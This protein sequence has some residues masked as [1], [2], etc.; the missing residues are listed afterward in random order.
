MN[1]VHSNDGIYALVV[2]FCAQVSERGLFSAE[3]DLSVHDLLQHGAEQEWRG[4]YYMHF[5]TLFS[6]YNISLRGKYVPIFFTKLRKS[7]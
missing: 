2:C 6:Y 4:L 7:K 3:A 5:P 1:M